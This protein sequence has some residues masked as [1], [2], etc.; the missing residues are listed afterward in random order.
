MSLA[1]S[2]VVGTIRIEPLVDGVAA[3]AAAADDSALGNLLSELAHRERLGDGERPIRLIAAARLSRCGFR[4]EQSQA[5]VR[6]DLVRLIE[7][8]EAEYDELQ[9]NAP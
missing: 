2:P 1:L 5:V 8:L 4:P 9:A 7:D 3:P 6:A